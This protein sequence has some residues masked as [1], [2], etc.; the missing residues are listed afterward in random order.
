LFFAQGCGFVWKVWPIIP[1]DCSGAGVV[2]VVTYAVVVVLSE[3][4]VGEGVVEGGVEEV[5]C[6]IIEEEVCAADAVVLYTAVVEEVN[7]IV[8]C[9]AVVGVGVDDVVGGVHTDV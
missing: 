4:V 7:A 3:G 2:V 9:P 1:Q 5:V 8:V 6:T